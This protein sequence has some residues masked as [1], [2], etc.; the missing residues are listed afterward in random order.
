MK[1]HS[2]IIMFFSVFL[3]IYAPFNSKA[4]DD[5]ITIKLPIEARV[6]SDTILIEDIAAINGPSSTQLAEI[7][8][9]AVGRSPRAGSA[10]QIYPGTI[11]KVL[12]DN[13][14]NLQEI[15]IESDGPLKVIRDFEIFPA[16]E[17]AAAVTAY[18]F[19]NA[20]WEDE[21]INVRPISFKQDLRLPPGKVALKVST[22][23]HS[24]WCG[25]E[26]FTVSVMVDQETVKQIRL[27]AFIEVWGTVV[28][29]TRPLGRGQ[30]IGP[31]DVAS[32]KMDLASAPVNAVVNK[33]YAV[34]S[35]VRR[36]IAINSI[37]RSDQIEL[38][39]LIRKGDVVEVIAE[40]RNIRISTKAVAQ[41]NGSLGERIVLLNLNSKKKIFAQVV[42]NRTVKVQM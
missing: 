30:P 21:Q 4:S 10:I 20:P 9:L 29:T 8:A 28:V 35:I 24:N 34:G 11:E 18:I 27:A 33:N 14:F 19:Q 39:P 22:S 40:A 23:K 15:R 3:L 13:G 36:S 2:A 31:D 42:D 38:P 1:Q 37:L 32:K 17:I 25:S 5:V 41:E 6:S 12:K 7:G 16:E 26:R